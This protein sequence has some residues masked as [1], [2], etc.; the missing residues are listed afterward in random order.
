SWCAL[1]SLRRCSPA[2]HL[3]LDHG[4]ITD[5][6][7]VRVQLLAQPLGIL[8]GVPSEVESTPRGEAQ[9]RRD[10]PLSLQRSLPRSA[11]RSPHRWAVGTRPAGCPA[12]SSSPQMPG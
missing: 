8:T 7:V 5:V 12:A 4:Y 2:L 1:R 6:Q 3:D 11:P 9:R 10:G